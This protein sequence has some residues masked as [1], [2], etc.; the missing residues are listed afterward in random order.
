MLQTQGDRTIRVVVGKGRVRPLPMARLAW[1]QTPSQ[2]LGLGPGLL[3]P[4]P[5]KKIA[6]SV[7]SPAAPLTNLKPRNPR[8]HGQFEVQRPLWNGTSLQMARAC[9]AGSRDA[10]PARQHWHH[11]RPQLFLSIPPPPAARPP[12]AAAAPGKRPDSGPTWRRILEPARWPGGQLRG[13]GLGWAGAGTRSCCWLHA[14][15]RPG[16]VSHWAE[17]L[18][19]GHHNAMKLARDATASGTTAR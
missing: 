17:P 19:A 5:R 11:D 2:A 4:G 7:D 13:P 9:S 6:P 14:N 12:A 10:A 8:E 18:C 1:A 16:R 3:A 15:A